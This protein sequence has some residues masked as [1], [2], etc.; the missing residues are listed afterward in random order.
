MLIL[1]VFKMRMPLKEI[2]PEEK[3][4]FYLQLDD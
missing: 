3:F 2:K 4:I 1:N